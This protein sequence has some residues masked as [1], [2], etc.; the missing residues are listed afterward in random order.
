MSKG[1]EGGRLRSALFTLIL[2]IYFLISIPICWSTFRWDMKQG[3]YFV[4]GTF[5]LFGVSLFCTC[6]RRLNNIWLGLLLLV[7]LSSIF[8]HNFYLTPTTINFMNFSLMCEGFIYVLCGILLYKLIYEYGTKDLRFYPGLWI[9]LGV[10]LIRKLHFINFSSSIWSI[11][12][13][14]AIG[15]LIY[16]FQKEKIFLFFIAGFS[17]LMA[18]VNNWYH[19]NLKWIVRQEAWQKTIDLIRQNPL[20]TG[21]QP[22]INANTVYVEAGAHNKYA[23]V[24]NDFLSITHDLGIFA[25]FCL[26]MYLMRLFRNVKIDKLVIACIMVLVLSC[27]KTT[28]YFT[29]NAILFI[30]LFSLMEMRK[31]DPEQN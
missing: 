29:R 28:W 19:I 9:A 4:F 23:F 15:T 31:Y 27:V 6:N 8:F 5:T 10:W 21:F 25:T 26:M 14:L 30:P 22:M 20:G 12:G 11:L 24:N 3:L 7:S 13:A 16:L 2:N 17:A 18:T 1:I